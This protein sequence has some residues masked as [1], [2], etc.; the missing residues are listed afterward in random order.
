[1]INR[2][3]D[4]ENECK[5][6]TRLVPEN[7]FLFNIIHIQANIKTLIA[8]LSTLVMVIKVNSPDAFMVDK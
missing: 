5:L 2:L 8:A 3:V 7:C 6:L 4:N 1:M